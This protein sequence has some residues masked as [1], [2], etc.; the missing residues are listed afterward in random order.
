MGRRGTD[1]DALSKRLTKSVGDIFGIDLAARYPVERIARA[2][3]RQTYGATLGVSTAIRNTLQ[4]IHT[5]VEAGPSAT[6]RGLKRMVTDRSS[7]DYK[8]FQEMNHD[9]MKEFGHDIMGKPEF[10]HDAKGWWKWIGREWKEAGELGAGYELTPEGKPYKEP[11]GKFEKWMRRLEIAHEGITELVL[12][13]MQFVENVNRGIAFFAG[14]EK[15]ARMGKHYAE[16]VPMGFREVI[17]TLPGLHITPEQWAG[18]QTMWKTQYQYSAA[19]TSPYFSSPFVKMMTMFWSYPLK[20]GQMIKNGFVENLPA[21][22]NKLKGIP[23][24]NESP[25]PANMP[26]LGEDAKFLRYLALIGFYVGGSAIT[27]ALGLDT[28]TLYS[29]RGLMP[30]QLTPTWA[31][32]IAQSYAVAKQEYTGEYDEYVDAWEPWKDTLGTMTLPAYRT[33]KTGFPGVWGELNDNVQRGY[34][35]L[36]AKELPLAETTWFDEFISFLGFPRSK[37]REAREDVYDLATKSR[38]YSNRK[39]MLAGRGAKAYSE[40]DYGELDQILKLARKEGIDLGMKD[41]QKAVEAKK[42]SA[43]DTKMRQAP[44]DLREQL[45]EEFGE[46]HAVIFERPVPGGR[47]MYSGPKQK[48]NMSEIIAMSAPKEPALGAEEELGWSA[49]IGEEG[50]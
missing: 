22:K 16:A 4:T 20:T 6:L 10:V 1:L 29:L 9:I 17:D 49:M 5:L 30:T 39:G 40:G 50:E 13:P 3:I 36:G 27:G 37:F 43:Y 47:R 8:F 45:Q 42:R 32:F 19:H 25:H 41:I 7:P 21:F 31:K 14:I 35:V 38:S 48:V 15:A 24:D 2:I 34:R 46:T 26:L 18:L 11:A 28:Y 33:I 12:S 44:K 23:V